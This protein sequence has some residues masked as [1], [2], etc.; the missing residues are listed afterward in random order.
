MVAAPAGAPG[1]DAALDAARE[2]AGDGS[3]VRALFTDAG[4]SLLA[5]PWPEC[6]RAAG[7]TTSLCARSA[8]ERGLS[9]EA[10]PGS[11]VWSSLTSFLAAAPAGHELWSLFP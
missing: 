4:L 6:L 8:R 7:A 5:G 1:V 9:P 2:A 10:V 3:A 11:V